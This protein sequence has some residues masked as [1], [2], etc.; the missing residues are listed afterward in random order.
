M[1]SRMTPRPLEHHEVVSVDNLKLALRYQLMM[2]QRSGNRDER[3]SVSVENQ[4]RAL[5]TLQNG[6]QRPLIGV[7]EIPG[8]FHIQRELIQNAKVRRTFAQ[9]PQCP[10]L[11]TVKNVVPPV[12]SQEFLFLNTNRRE[13]YNRSHTFRCDVGHGQHHSSAH[14]EANQLGLPNPKFIQ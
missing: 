5:V 2:L 3:I 12:A 13:Q 10:E 9:Q 14:A 11:C 1:G 8:I 6:S 7:I 4:H